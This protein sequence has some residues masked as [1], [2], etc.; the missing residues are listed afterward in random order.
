MCSA[1][2]LAT[3]ELY[4][5]FMRMLRNFRLAPAAPGDDALP[6][7]HPRTDMK[8]PRDLI[9]AP[10]PY[11]VRC[12]PRDAERLRQALDAAALMDEQEDE[13]EKG[14]GGAERAWAFGKQA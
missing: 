1:H 5:V 10:R 13:E 2:I 7:C 9:M 4:L 14:G 8:N 11:R 3:R 12:V 6:A